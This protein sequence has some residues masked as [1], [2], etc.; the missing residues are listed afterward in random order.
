MDPKD[1]IS[2]LMGLDDTFLQVNGPT[3]HFT[4]FGSNYGKQE[5]GLS[6]PLN[7]TN[8]GYMYRY[9]KQGIQMDTSKGKR[10]RSTTTMR[11][12]TQSRTFYYTRRKTTSNF[13]NMTPSSDM[14]V[15]YNKDQGTPHQPSCCASSTIP[16]SE[17]RS[18]KRGLMVVRGTRAETSPY[19]MISLEASGDTKAHV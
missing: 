11:R 4:L 19:S 2:E 18:M 10:K 9:M 13:Q 7:M 12:E 14:L 6:I 5:A 3:M 15:D 1:A 16:S 8:H 17:G